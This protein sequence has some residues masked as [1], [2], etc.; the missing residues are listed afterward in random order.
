MLHQFSSMAA[1][2]AACFKTAVSSAFRGNDPRFY[3]KLRICSGH[4]QK[5]AGG[6]F[7]MISARLPGFDGLHRHP[8]VLCKQH[9]RHP[10]FFPDRSYLIGCEPAHGHDRQ[11]NCLCVKHAPL[12]IDCLGQSG[13]DIAKDTHGVNQLP[14]F[15]FLHYIIPYLIGAVKPF[16]VIHRTPDYPSESFPS[17]LLCAYFT[18]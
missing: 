2:F 3:R 16:F 13:F 6:A 14:P 12:I 18:E 17:S 8:D 10:C 9:L 5:P 11:C 4:S 7:G 15:V 1:K